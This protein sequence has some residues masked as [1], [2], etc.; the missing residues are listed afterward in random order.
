MARG[1]W[2][3]REHISAIRAVEDELNTPEMRRAIAEE[4]ASQHDPLSR[5]RELHGEHWMDEE[6]KD[7]EEDE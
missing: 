6:Q 7:W 5:V 3:A 4:I 2:N 1:K